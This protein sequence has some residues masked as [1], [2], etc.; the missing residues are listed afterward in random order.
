MKL[1]VNTSFTRILNCNLDTG[2]RLAPPL[3]CC[4]CLLSSVGHHLRPIGLRWWPTSSFRQTT[5]LRYAGFALRPP[6]LASPLHLSSPLGNSSH[7]GRALGPSR[8][9]SLPSPCALAMRLAR[10]AP[11]SRPSRA[12]LAPVSR[13]SRARLAPVYTTQHARAQASGSGLHF[14]LRRARNPRVSKAHVPPCAL[15]PARSL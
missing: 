9:A 5:T 11:V 12:R 8:F 2:A 1:I 7:N 15:S 6:S 14:R 10:L 13:P 3:R 4:V